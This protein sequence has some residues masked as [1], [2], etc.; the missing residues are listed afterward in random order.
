M[1][2][3]LKEIMILEKEA[4]DSLLKL[5]EEQFS[6]LIKKDVFALDSMV[7]KIKLC[8]KDVAEYEVKRRGILKNLS[9][10]E[11]IQ[12]SSDKELKSIFNDIKF[13]L[14]DLKIQKD[15]N[16]LLIKQNLSFTT[17]MLSH[18]NPKRTPSTYNSYGKI[19]R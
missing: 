9:L 19:K 12:N 17:K 1:E 11:V 3:K 16:D 14:N 13:I 18:I 2:E 7:D 4:L 10:K 5:L 6:L 15:S 8:N